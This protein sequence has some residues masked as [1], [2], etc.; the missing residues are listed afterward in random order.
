MKWSVEAGLR[1]IAVQCQR[2]CSQNRIC[3]FIRFATHYSLSCIDACYLVRQVT[4]NIHIYATQC[5]VFTIVQNTGKLERYDIL[6]LQDAVHQYNTHL[7]ESINT[8]L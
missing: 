3:H 2:L 8:N 5:F 1:G 6:R 4:N 7:I